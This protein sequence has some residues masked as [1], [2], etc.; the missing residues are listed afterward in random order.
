MEHGSQVAT[1]GSVLTDLV[2]GMRPANHEQPVVECLSV[3]IRLVSPMQAGLPLGALHLRIWR[4]L[5]VARGDV[6]E[7]DKHGSTEFIQTLTPNCELLTLPALPR[8]E[9]RSKSSREAAPRWAWGVVL[10]EWFSS[11]QPSL[12]PPAGE[13]VTVSAVRNPRLC[14]RNSSPRCLKP[15]P[16]SSLHL[17]PLRTLKYSITS[18]TCLF[19][20]TVVT[21]T[22]RPTSLHLQISFIGYQRGHPMK[23][24]R[25]GREI[26]KKWL[27]YILREHKAATDSSTLLQVDNFTV[28]KDLGDG[29]NSQVIFFNVETTEKNE[30][31]SPDVK[32]TYSLVAKLLNEETGSRVFA[33]KFKINLKEYLVYTDLINTF[34]KIL[35]E[36]APEESLISLPKL[37]YGKCTK[38]DFVLVMENVENAGYETNDKCKGLD[39]EQLMATVDKIA[40]IHALSYVFCETSDTSKYLSLPRIDEYF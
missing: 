35:T 22:K 13:D 9:P 32:K 18:L 33:T 26:S 20:L 21:S 2:G 40:R 25:S 27:E 36:K 15:R 8:P 29:Y 3:P 11:T 1:G 7:A 30:A 4:K 14:S 34:N 24:P 31:N 10:S 39:S 5:A 17:H 37:I 23:T 19:S 12:T 16:S 28:R 6:F 38:N